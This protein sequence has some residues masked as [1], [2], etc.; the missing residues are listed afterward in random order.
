MAF[1]I[2]GDSVTLIKDCNETTT[3]MLPRDRDSILSSEGVITIGFDLLDENGFY[4]GDVQTL[5]LASTPDEAYYLC[6]VHAKDCN[7]GDSTAHKKFSH[8]SKNSTTNNISSKFPTGSETWENSRYFEQNQFTNE[9]Q[10]FNS[11]S[12]SEE[13]NVESRNL[14]VH[15]EIEVPSSGGTQFTT[16]RDNYGTQ[17]NSFEENSSP[18][19]SYNLVGPNYN[20]FNKNRSELVTEAATTVHE[21]NTEVKIKFY[22][23]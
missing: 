12:F 17:S 8:Y 7:L 9:Y 22:A 11:S 13:T 4:K 16:P 3:K 18:T 2:K 23:K 15:S 5:K 21:H 1:S 19:N 6:E 14:N 10:K 20:F